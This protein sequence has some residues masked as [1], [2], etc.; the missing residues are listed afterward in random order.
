[1][2]TVLQFDEYLGYPAWRQGEFL[3][4]KNLCKARGIEYKYLGVGWLSVAVE[5]TAIRS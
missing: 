3:A 4:W 1:V 2:G 5:I